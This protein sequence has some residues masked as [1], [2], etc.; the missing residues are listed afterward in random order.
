M[1]LTWKRPRRV[2]V[3][4]FGRT[5]NDLLR[6]YISEESSVVYLSPLVELNVWV[7]L[8]MLFSGGISQT[9]YYHAFLQLTKP[10]CVI[11]MEDNNLVFYST[12][13]AQP[14]C[15]TLA[16]Q[17]GLRVLYS[18]TPNSNFF[19]DLKDSTSR[20]YGVDVCATMGSASSR[21]YAEALGNRAIRIVETGSLRNNA[22]V[23]GPPRSSDQRRR[24]VFISSFPNLGADGI[25]PDWDSRVV[26]YFGDVGLTNSEYFRIEGV[27]ARIAAES[28]LDR[29]LEF[30][31][32]GKRP[33][34]Q[35]GERR[36]FQ[37]SIGDLKWRYLP[38]D[39][40][41][42]SYESIADSDLVIT[43]DSTLGYEFFARGLRVAFVA[44][45]MRLA[46]FP[47]VRE[48]IFA[49]LTHSE[50]QGPIWTDVCT[51]LEVN[52]LI[53][54]LLTATDSQWQAL[55]RDLRSKVVCFDDQNRCFCAILSELGIPNKGPSL[56]RRDLIPSN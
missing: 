53:D 27:V 47:N 32:L 50:D 2:Q 18:H 54:Y 33:N 35:I 4:Y 39:H 38:S 41:A 17:N 24:L 16:I 51:T 36:F 15:R 12:K 20:G 10:R 48:G 6:N 46:G 19:K 52:R 43:T 40:Q 26:H 1:R 34:W 30:C 7:S 44:S 45:R 29:G 42:S 49:D 3:V 25:D 21:L 23:L 8:K 22:L 37:S 55:T 9:R 11:T 31:V 56:W 28:A 14:E 5:G 13:C